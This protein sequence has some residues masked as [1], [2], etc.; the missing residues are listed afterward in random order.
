MD[1][2]YLRILDRCRYGEVIPLD[3]RRAT[4]IAQALVRRRLLAMTWQ[5]GKPRYSATE[6][7]MTALRESP[8]L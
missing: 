5:D 4:E 8:T 6:A 1:K 2:S 3:D 7:G